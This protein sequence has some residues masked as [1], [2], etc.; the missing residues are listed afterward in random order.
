MV[1]GYLRPRA[2]LPHLSSLELLALR[3]LGLQHTYIHTYIYI[4]IH[5]RNIYIY[6]ERERE[7]TDMTFLMLLLGSGREVRT[8][9]ALAMLGSA[10]F[11]RLGVWPARKRR[12][13]RDLRK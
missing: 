11:L 1:W 8:M 9:T 7:Y 2:P 12:A 5:I 13:R 4:Y 6:R 3:T 10:G